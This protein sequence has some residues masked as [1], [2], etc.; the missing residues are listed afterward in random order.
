MFCA[1]KKIGDMSNGNKDDLSFHLLQVCSEINFL[2]WLELHVGMHGGHSPP[3]HRSLRKTRDALQF[4]PKHIYSEVE[5]TGA[6]PLKAY[7]EINWA[8]Y[9][10]QA[11][12]LSFCGLWEENSWSEC[13]KVE[14]KVRLY[15]SQSSSGLFLSFSLPTNKIW[16]PC[17]S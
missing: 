12:Q 5:L 6:N 14:E 8:A 13:G 3:R 9:D 17:V 16:C 15:F 11:S 10:S 4:H 7:I 1:E 2:C